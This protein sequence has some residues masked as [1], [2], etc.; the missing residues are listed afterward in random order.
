MTDPRIEKI[1]DILLNYST[2]VKKGDYVQIISDT[3]A[4]PL[5]KVLYK[6]IMEKEAFP[7]LKINFPWTNYQYYKHSSDFHLENF[8]EIQYEEI[9]KTDVFMRI[10]AGKNVKSLSNIDPNKI[11]KRQK[12]TEKITKERLKKRWVVFDY[13]SDA[14]AQ[15]AEMSTEEFEDFVTK[16]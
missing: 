7:V 11:S 1:A 12:T 8:P 15:E 5:I 16:S 10:E 6:K 14:L 4:E 3:E 2:K 9:K 13:P